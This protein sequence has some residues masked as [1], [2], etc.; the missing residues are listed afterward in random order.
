MERPGQIDWGVF[1]FRIGHKVGKVG[2]E[3]Q[4]LSSVE[5]DYYLKLVDVATR[6]RMACERY[7]DEHDHPFAS[8]VRFPK[9]CCTLASVGLWFFLQEEGIGE[10]ELLNFQINPKNVLSGHDIV[11]IQG[12]AIDIT[13]DQF[14]F[15]PPP[16]YFGKTDRRVIV[17]RESELPATWRLLNRFSSRNPTGQFKDEKRRQMYRDICGYLKP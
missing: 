10:G 3:L 5:T 14:P 13:A 11:G 17:Q 4:D 8:M 6:F 15:E 1:F 12:W 16:S 9:D 7:R 2:G